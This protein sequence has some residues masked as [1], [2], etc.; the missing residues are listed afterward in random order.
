MGIFGNDKA[1][2][3]TTYYNKAT[4]KFGKKKYQ[5]AIKYYDKA[6]EL[7]PDYV[8]AW[9]DKGVALIRLGK[10]DEGFRNKS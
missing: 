9:N 8:A 5:E 3:D 6:L 10:Y 7:N 1:E 4:V 2:N